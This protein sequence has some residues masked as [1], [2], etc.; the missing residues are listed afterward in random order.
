MAEERLACGHDPHDV[1][2]R[3][4]TVKALKCEPAVQTARWGRTKAVDR[5]AEVRL[6]AHVTQE[7]ARALGAA[8]V[9]ADRAEPP[10]GVTA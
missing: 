4:L 3:N 1:M 8:L 7:E 9:G 2:G 6:L 10:V 5:V